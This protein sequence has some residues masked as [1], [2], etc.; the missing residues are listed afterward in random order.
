MGHLS[1]QI[2]KIVMPL[3]HDPLFDVSSEHLVPDLFLPDLS[4][5]SL[6]VTCRSVFVCY[7]NFYASFQVHLPIRSIR[8]GCQ[9]VFDGAAERIKL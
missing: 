3:S 6:H 5:Y 7:L 9:D 2:Q 8:E 1:L 4:Q